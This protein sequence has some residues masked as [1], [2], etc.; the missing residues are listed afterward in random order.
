MSEDGLQTMD[1]RELADRCLKILRVIPGQ[2]TLTLHANVNVN[3]LKSKLVTTEQVYRACASDD[4]IRLDTSSY[5]YHYY[6][7]DMP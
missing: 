1:E 7:K 6:P 4:R 3:Q 5:P 2:T